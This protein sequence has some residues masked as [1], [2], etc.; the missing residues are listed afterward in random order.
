MRP[1]LTKWLVLQ[2]HNPDSWSENEG[3]ETNVDLLID[4]IHDLTSETDSL[5]QQDIK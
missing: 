3:T 2:R 5:N 4:R 1:G